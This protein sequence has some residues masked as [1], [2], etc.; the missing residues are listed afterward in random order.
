MENKY[1]LDDLRQKL[2][3]YLMKQEIFDVPEIIIL[4]LLLKDNECDISEL[5]NKLSKVI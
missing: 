5:A 1:T 3:D 2:I 4:Q